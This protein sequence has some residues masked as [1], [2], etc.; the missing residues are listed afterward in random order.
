MIQYKHVTVV[1]LTFFFLKLLDAI[2][3]RDTVD[4]AAVLFLM[5]IAT[6]LF[7]VIIYG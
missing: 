7:L 6:F 2:R 3:K 5:V 4:A 1:A